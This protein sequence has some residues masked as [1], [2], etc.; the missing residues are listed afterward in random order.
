MRSYN[1]ANILHVHTY[2]F[3][4]ELLPTTVVL[5]RQHLD[6]LRGHRFFSELRSIFVFDILQIASGC[7]QIF[8]DVHCTHL[9]TSD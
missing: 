6:A 3:E 1:I 2:I 9:Q 8:S 5:Q 4:N 7:I